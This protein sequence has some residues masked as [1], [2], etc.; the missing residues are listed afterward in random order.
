MHYMHLLF[1]ENGKGLDIHLIRLILWWIP[2][3]FC[4]TRGILSQDPPSRHDLVVVEFLHCCDDAV[5]R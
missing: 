1:T 3:T 5:V 2:S 4:D